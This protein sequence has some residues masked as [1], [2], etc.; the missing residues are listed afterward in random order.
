MHKRILNNL[1][2]L[3]IKRK[4]KLTNIS[5]FSRLIFYPD[6]IIQSF[7]CFLLNKLSISLPYQTKTFWG[8]RMKII[9]PEVISSDLRRF[10]FIEHTVA[11]FIINNCSSGDEVIDVGSHFGFF[12]LLMSEVVGKKGSVHCFEPTPSTFSILKS[13]VFNID[14]IFINQKAV[15]DKEIEIELN[16]YGLTSSAFNSI[17]NSREKKRINK[18]NQSKIFVKTTSLDYT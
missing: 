18:L 9:L 7:L 2:E 17:K 12:S 15:L 3:N 10:G 16:D 11:S 6:M 5:F 8:K 14:N 13:N 1:L 4:N